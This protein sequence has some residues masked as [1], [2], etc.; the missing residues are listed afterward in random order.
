MKPGPTRRDRGVGAVERIKP[1]VD[2]VTTIRSDGS[3]RFLHPADSRGP[4]LRWRRISAWLLIAVYV[5]LPWIPIG[6]FPTVFM[7]VAGRRFH[8]F[9]YTLATQDI[10]VFFFLVSGL[11]FILFFVTALLGR[12]WCGWACPQTVFLEHVYRRIERWIEGD[13]FVRRRLDSAGWDTKKILQRGLKHSLFIA[14]SAIVA[15]VFLAYFVSLPEV[16]AMVSGSPGEHWGAFVFMATATGTLYFNFAWFREQLCLIIC[17][18]GRLQSA[19]IDDHSVVIGY[20]TDRGEPRGKPGAVAGD[21]VDCR[22]CVQV[23][24]TGIDIRHGLQME[25]IGCAACVDAC[26]EVMLRLKR[27]R[28]LVRYDSLA[29]FGGGVTRLIRARTVVYTVLLVIGAAVMTWSFS[30][31][32]GSALQ[33]MRMTG[34]SY[35]VDADGIRNQYFIRI[36]NKRAEGANFEVRAV[37]APDGM[38]I[39]GLDEAVVVAGMADV[40]RPLVVTMPR[41]HYGGPASFTVEMKDARDGGLIRGKVE[42]VGPDPKLLDDKFWNR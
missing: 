20:D 2:T 19:M 23:C 40:V 21:C 16:Y 8:Y 35:F 30:T 5:L 11:G 22:R 7:D 34:S 29:G 33:V 3:R 36:T 18:Y 15:H 17:P 9:G 14:V 6:G 13:A 28:G 25:C 37:G 41:S 26:D 32:R 39:A 12:V 10:W 24:P 1:S 42:F 4:F 27:P 31:V 38:R